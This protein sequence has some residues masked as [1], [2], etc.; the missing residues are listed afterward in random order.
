MAMTPDQVMMFVQMADWVGSRMAP[1]N[2]FA[3]FGSQLG[4]SR[5][6]AKM[7]QTP[8][9]PGAPGADPNAAPPADPSALAQP[10]P[11]EA[12][13]QSPQLP[14]KVPSKPSFGGADLSGIMSP[15]EMDIK[16]LFM[17]PGMDVKSDANNKITMSRQIPAPIQAGAPAKK[18]DSAQ[19]LPSS[20]T[21]PFWFR[22]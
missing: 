20:V 8:G 3:G 21:N 13:Y 11:F 2:P 6:Y 7:L 1:E 19:N 17:T 15:E 22:G 10:N 18:K 5:N 4:A 12:G 14:E 16:D 9:A